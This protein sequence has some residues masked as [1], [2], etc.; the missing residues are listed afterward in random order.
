MGLLESAEMEGKVVEE[1]IGGRLKDRGARSIGAKEK[2]FGDHRERRGVMVGRREMRGSKKE[3]ED[4][5]EEKNWDCRD[6]E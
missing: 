4:G 5:E 3:E 2:P 6:S 1:A